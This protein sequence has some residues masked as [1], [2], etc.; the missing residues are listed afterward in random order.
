MQTANAA[1]RR[2]P[3]MPLLL[4]CLMAL[5]LTAGRVGAEPPIAGK[6]PGEIVAAA[7]AA[8]WRD[9]ADTDLLVMTLAGGKQVVLQLAPYFS[10]THVGNI[11][12]LALAHWWDGTS[13]YRVQDNYVVQW[14]DRSETK[15]LPPGVDPHPP[16]DYTLPAQG[17]HL[18]PLASP[19]AYA[20]VTGF[21]EG[22]PVAGDG[23]SLWLT[24][25]YGMVG[26]GRDLSPDAGTGAELYAVLGPARPL[27]RNI[28][29]VARVIEGMEILSELPRGTEPLGM[30]AAA[31]PPTPIVSIRL[32]SDLPPAERPHFQLMDTASAAF[33]E[34]IHV[35]ANRHDAF[36][37][38][39][40]GGVDI[41]NVPVPI[42]RKPN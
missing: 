3:A 13:I 32:A 22:W 14:G 29:L 7:P 19:D 17:L 30:Y 11:R 24:H 9:I 33:A 27:D 34:Y 36:F 39:P 6:T 4:P 16:A 28:A 38:V 15:P 42:R 41:T 26:A 1:M 25:C 18:T 8:A 5:L 2:S 23:K 21:V 20:R 37:S 31:Q 12:T 40:A 10:P 35:R